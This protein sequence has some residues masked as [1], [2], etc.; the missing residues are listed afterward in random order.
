MRQKP[1]TLVKSGDPKKPPGQQ[2]GLA[3]EPPSNV[4]W[5]EPSHPAAQVAFFG[6]PSPVCNSANHM[7]ARG[8]VGRLALIRFGDRTKKQ[9]PIPIQ[10]VAVNSKTGGKLKFENR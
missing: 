5:L 6:S 1:Y 2:V 3:S 10:A 9:L 8:I 4:R 7:A